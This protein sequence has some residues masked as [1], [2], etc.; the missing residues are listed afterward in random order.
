MRRTLIALALALASCG[1]GGRD[2]TVTPPA[3]MP[4]EPPEAI[5]RWADIT[6]VSC[7][8]DAFGA[9][10]SGQVTN[11]N[12]DQP[13]SFMITTEFRD[14][15]GVMYATALTLTKEVAPDESTDWEGRT[16]TPL[17]AIPTDEGGDACGAEITE[18][19]AIVGVLGRT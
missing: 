6:N 12:P 11:D 14:R 8:S 4:T 9:Y 1:G 19:E 15:A 18:V 10:V 16:G 13:F 3:P 2:L 7:G 17:A 5:S